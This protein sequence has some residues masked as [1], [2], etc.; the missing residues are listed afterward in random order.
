MTFV[1][2]DF[3]F[4]FLHLFLLFAFLPPPSKKLKEMP[5][6]KAEGERRSGHSGMWWGNIMNEWI[7]RQKSGGNPMDME[8]PRSQS[9]AE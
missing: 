8:R 9:R 2:S 6:Q 4:P 7:G 5:Q 3:P 1:A